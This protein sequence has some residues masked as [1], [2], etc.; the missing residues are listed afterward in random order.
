V[1]QLS[2]ARKNLRG[3]TTFLIVALQMNTDFQREDHRYFPKNLRL[4]LRKSADKS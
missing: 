3:K 2:T 1:S 4:N